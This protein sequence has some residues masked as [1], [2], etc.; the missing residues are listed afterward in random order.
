MAARAV[1]VLAQNGISQKELGQ[2]LGMVNGAARQGATQGFIELEKGRA[3]MATGVTGP[4]GKQIVTPTRIDVSGDRARLQKVWERTNALTAAMSAVNGERMQDGSKVQV[5]PF[6][7]PQDARTGVTLDKS[8][9][10]AQLS[11]MMSDLYRGTAPI[12]FN[13][14]EV[15]DKLGGAR[16]AEV[17]R[18]ALELEQKRVADI[19]ERVGADK[20]GLIT[21]NVMG[22]DVKYRVSDIGAVI[23]RQQAQMDQ[24]DQIL[25]PRNRADARERA[26]EQETRGARKTYRDRTANLV[27]RLGATSE[28]LNRNKPRI[29]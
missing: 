10:V 7:A 23:A 20:D 27:K 25:D 24:L 6:V 16:N 29:R 18:R 2:A 13:D 3:Q 8:G 14:K 9:F 15:I 4:D 11:Q 19:V 26:V 17:I 12:D 21:V 1:Q 5:S 22:K 28:Y